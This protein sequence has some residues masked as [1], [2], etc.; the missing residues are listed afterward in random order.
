MSWLTRV[1]F[2]DSRIHGRGVFAAERI[3]AGTKIWAFDSNMI[4]AEGPQDLLR[5][6]RPLLAFALHGGYLHHP[7]DRFV[8]YYDGMQY[9]NHA[10]AERANIGITEWTP[11]RQDNCSALRDIEIGEELLEDYAFWSVAKLNPNH[12]LRNVYARHCSDHYN[13]L[14]R[15]DSDP[16]VAQVA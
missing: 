1:E 12:W 7:S 9:V 11:L 8:W 2:R 4:V 5:L 6:P 15:L 3:P 16:K 10:P 13:F 14:L